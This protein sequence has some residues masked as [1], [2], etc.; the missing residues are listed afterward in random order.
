MLQG[1][2]RRL[3]MIYTV[4]KGSWKSAIDSCNDLHSKTD[5][6]RDVSSSADVDKSWHERGQIATS[7]DGVGSDIEHELYVDK[8]IISIV[9]VVCSPSRDEDQSCSGRC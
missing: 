6:S 1:N 2:Y 3:Q 7:R 9:Q 4:A 8:S 5:D